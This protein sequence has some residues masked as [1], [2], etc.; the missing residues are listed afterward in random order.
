MLLQSSHSYGSEF[1]KDDNSNVIFGVL[2]N[3]RAFFP[4]HWSQTWKFSMLSV[5]GFQK[6]E[7]V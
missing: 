1:L 2:P 3:N 6:D 5:Y 4:T 7:E